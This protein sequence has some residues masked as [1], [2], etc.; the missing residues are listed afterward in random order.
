MM[1]INLVGKEITKEFFSLRAFTRRYWAV[2]LT[3][4]HT[5]CNVC[6]IM[7]E[8]ASLAVERM[9]QFCTHTANQ[10]TTKNWVDKTETE[11]PERKRLSVCR[12]IFW[13]Q[14]EWENAII[15]VSCQL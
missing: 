13:V 6:H 1:A 9:K 8:E 4:F 11:S 7:P 3:P 5:Y 2:Q 12:N 10:I 15:F 14:I